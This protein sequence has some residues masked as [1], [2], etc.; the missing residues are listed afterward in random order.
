[1]IVLKENLEKLKETPAIYALKDHIMQ[2]MNWTINEL[3]SHLDEMMVLD[4]WDDESLGEE[5]CRIGYFGSFSPSLNNYVDYKKIG[6]NTLA[7]Y[8]TWSIPNAN[9]LIIYFD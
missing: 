9:I 4:A 7:D 3:I 6:Q 1:M 8:K 2:D 5:M